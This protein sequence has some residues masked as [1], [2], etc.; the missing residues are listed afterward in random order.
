[1]LAQGYRKLA[2]CGYVIDHNLPFASCGVQ[3]HTTSVGDG[4]Q[5]SCAI[6]Q[7]PIHVFPTP[8]GVRRRF[9]RV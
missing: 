5:E 2:K 6:R 9:W 3:M 7:L 1:M 8:C 4:G